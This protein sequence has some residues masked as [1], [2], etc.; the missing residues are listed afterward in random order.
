MAYSELIKSFNRTREYM[1]QFYIFGFKSREEYGMK[2]PR[3]YDDEKRRVES[4]LGEYMRFRQGA[5]GK[6]VFLSIDS[7]SAEANPLFKAWRAK[8]FTDIDITLHFLI[9]DILYAEGVALTLG[10][11]IGGIEKRLGEFARPRFFDES[12]VRKKLKEYELEGIISAERRGRSTVYQRSASLFNEA[13]PPMLPHA[14]RFFSEVAP[15]GVIGSFL[16][17]KYEKNGAKARR[18]PVFGFKHHIITFTVDEEIVFA[19]F[20]AMREKRLV[21]LELLARDGRSMTERVVPLKI[22]RG[23]QSGRQ[24]LMARTE[25]G[26]ILPYRL[27]NVLSV[28]KDEVCGQFDEYR[29]ALAA[30]RRHLWG[31]STHG[32]SGKRLERVEFTVRC[33]AGEEHILA[34]L[35]REKRCGSVERLDENR[36]RFTAEVY[37]ASELIP[38]IRSFICRIESLKISDGFLEA[39]FRHDLEK[40]YALYGVGGGAE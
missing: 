32:R 10:E 11:I 39:R 20:E 12:T 38:W 27:D 22:L 17:E 2:S 35:E 21:L 28:K 24:Y 31:V 13:E 36:L 4:W 40:M 29:A 34:R 14:L 30:M 9:F 5:D 7:R 3:S 25:A 1:R 16:L 18:S 15:C 8:S 6:T 37:D 19:L 23:V 33:E 26:R